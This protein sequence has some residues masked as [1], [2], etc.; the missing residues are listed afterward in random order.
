MKTRI[1]VLVPGEPPLSFNF[2]IT[3]LLNW[4]EMSLNKSRGLARPDSVQKVNSGLSGEKEVGLCTGYSTC[5]PHGL[6]L[7]INN[8]SLGNRIVTLVDMSS[9]IK[10][11]LK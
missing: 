8:F 5:L 3:Q 4:K 7:N 11:T 1:E 6:F 9:L 10:L 2:P